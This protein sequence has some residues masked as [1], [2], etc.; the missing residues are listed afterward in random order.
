MRL[1]IIALLAV[2][3]GGT[4]CDSGREAERES[5]KA[6]MSYEDA[7]TRRYFQRCSDRMTTLQSQV[8]QAI[9]LAEGWEKL[10]KR[11]YVVT[12]VVTNVVTVTNECA[13]QH[14]PEPGQSMTLPYTPSPWPTNALPVYYAVTTQCLNVVGSNDTVTVHMKD[15]ASGEWIRFPLFKEPATNDAV[16]KPGTPFSFRALTNNTNVDGVEK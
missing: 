9:A 13:R 12:V 7:A 16:E 1:K 15:A 5:R 10:Y 11:D 3:V 4:G 6:L 14:W 2:I 8:D